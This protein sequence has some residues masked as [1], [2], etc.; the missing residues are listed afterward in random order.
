MYAMT[1]AAPIEWD[2]G[3]LVFGA[4]LVAGGLALVHRA[5]MKASGR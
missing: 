1:L 3:F 2:I 4:L 5:S